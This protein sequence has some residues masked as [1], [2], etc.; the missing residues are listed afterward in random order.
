LPARDAR[1]SLPIATVEVAMSST[2]GRLR[3][4]GAAN[5]IGLVP[6]RGSAAKVG[7][8]AATVTPLVDSPIR[9]ASA[10][11]QA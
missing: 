3:P 8:V 4:A 9:P 6:K 11:I 1:T 7:T 10:A 2:N 5:A